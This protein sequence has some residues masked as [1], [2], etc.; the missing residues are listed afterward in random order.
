MSL[1]RNAARVY[2]FFRRKQLEKKNIRPHFF[3]A[4]LIHNLI[5][6]SIRTNFG[7]DHSFREIINYD[8]FKQ[9]VPLRDYE[10][11]RPYIQKIID[12]E[13]NILWPGLPLYFAKTSGTTSGAKFIPITRESVPNHISGA[14]DV[15]LTYIEQTQKCHFLDG[16]MMF[17]SGSPRLEVLPGGILLGRL[18]GIAQHFVPSY[19]Q[20]NRVPSFETNC[21]DDWEE[22]IDKIVSETLHV[23]LRLISGIPPWVQMFFEK[24]IEK[25]GKPPCEVWKNLQLFVQGGVDFSPYQKIFFE[26]LGKKVDVL[27]VY[28]ASEGFIAFQN[29]FNDPGLLLRVDSGIFFEFIPLEDYHKPEPDQYRISLTDVKIGVVYALILSTN[30][31]LWAYDIGDAVEFVSINPYKLKVVGRVKHFISAFGE[32]VIESEVNFSLDQALQR[33][34]GSVIEYTVAP[35]IT[36]QVSSHEWLIEFKNPPENLELFSEEL[37]KSLM[38]KNCYYKDLRTG[39][40]LSKPV[41]TILKENTCK[42]YMKSQGKLGGQNK[43]VRLSNNRKI[44]ESLISISKSG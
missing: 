20:T 30:A 38:N 32:H 18:S 22:K 17:L 12:G 36:E 6:S 5:H 3:Q 26:L 28:P 23:D 43:F 27:E 42:E 34:G 4:Q 15:L 21:I 9:A 8:H 1:K 14:R 39:N 2:A 19:L 11:L 40:I 16:K 44:A 33:T 10:K 13:K 25:S 31:G 37:D 41:I 29:D 7:K 24:V 35:L